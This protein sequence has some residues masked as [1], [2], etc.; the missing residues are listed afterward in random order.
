LRLRTKRLSGI[1]LQRGIVIFDYEAAALPGRFL[2]ELGRPF[3]RAAIFFP[4]RF[5]CALNASRALTCFTP[6]A[7]DAPAQVAKSPAQVSLKTG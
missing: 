3:K 7:R 6:A 2:P 1:L 4:A 5:R